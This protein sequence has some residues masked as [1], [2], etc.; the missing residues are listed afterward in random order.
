MEKCFRTGQ[1]MPIACWIP[2]A[3]NTHSEDVILISFPLQQW[4]HECT[5]VLRYMYIVMFK[6]VNM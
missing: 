6:Y 4:L 3:A 1:A 5:S 2:K